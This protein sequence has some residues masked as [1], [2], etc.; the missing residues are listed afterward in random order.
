[1]IDNQFIECQFCFIPFLREDFRRKYCSKRCALDYA[2]KAQR[3]KRRNKLR[4]EGL[5]IVGE[6]IICFHPYCDASFIKNGNR[7]FCSSKCAVAY[8]IK[9]N[10]RIGFADAC[11]VYFHDC[12]D[13]GRKVCRSNRATVMKKCNICGPLARR[14]VDARKNH[15]RRS[16]RK[17]DLTVSDLAKRDGKRCHICK[18]IIDINLPGNTRFGPSIDHLIPISWGGTNDANNLALAHFICNTVRGNR[19]PAQLLLIA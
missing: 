15:K 7:I 3:E 4:A 19:E 13:C 6:T 8:R 2:H 1:M 12:P 10:S 5:P 9:A 17:L 16:A 11:P 18:K 14:A